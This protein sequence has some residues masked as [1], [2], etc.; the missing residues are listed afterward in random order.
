MKDAK[1]E[2]PNSPR[3]VLVFIKMTGW[4]MGNYEDG[5]WRLYFSDTGLQLTKNPH[6][7]THWQEFPVIPEL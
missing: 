3:D 7:I 2:Q 4:M 1:T 6:L 5:K